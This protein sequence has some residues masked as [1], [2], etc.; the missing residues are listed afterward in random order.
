MSISIGSDTRIADL[1]SSKAVSFWETLEETQERRAVANQ[2]V[3]ARVGAG[4]RGLQKQT[5]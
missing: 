5:A 4:P 2:A 3:G 1:S